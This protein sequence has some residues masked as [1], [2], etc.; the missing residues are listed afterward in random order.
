MDRWASFRFFS[1]LN[2]FLP[3][4]KKDI[5][6][7]YHFSGLPA[8]KDSIEAIGVPHPE[9]DVILINSRPA[10]LTTPLHPRDQVEVYP[11]EPQNGWAPGCSL[12]ISAPVPARFILDVHLGKLARNLRLLGFDA[13]YRNDYS[14]QVIAALATQES[15]L[16][17]T[18]DIGLLKQKAIIWG[19][20]LRSQDPAVQ[21]AEVIRYFQLQQQ[22]APFTRCLACN[23]RIVSVAKESVWEDLPPNTRRYFQEFYQCTQCKRV[24]WKGSHFD[25]MQSFINDQLSMTNDQ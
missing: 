3:P 23:A 1:S 20:W 4:L 25:R 5:A 17:L 8:V 24:Y 19:Y 7:P 22:L 2:D 11:F 15:R 6:F 14:D 12:R 10:Q 9:V 18:R 21:L 16:V 13:C